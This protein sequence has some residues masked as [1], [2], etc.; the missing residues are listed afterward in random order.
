MNTRPDTLNLWE[1][2]LLQGHGLRLEPDGSPWVVLLSSSLL[3]GQ[4][5]DPDKAQKQIA[6]YRGKLCKASCN[7]PFLL[8]GLSYYTFCK[9][10]TEGRRPISQL[11]S[12][13][14]THFF[15]LLCSA[16]HS[17]GFKAW[18]DGSESGLR[19][20]QHVLERLASL[21]RSHTDLLHELTGRNRRQPVLE[22][23]AFPPGRDSRCCSLV[24]NP[25]WAKKIK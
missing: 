6:C 19:E 25:V 18:M 11:E 20:Y 13:N 15:P 22:G 23:F 17:Q 1:H 24:S 5:T 7:I 9:V 21:S 4:A 10:K 3:Q 16:T 2:D 12:P 8:L 14:V